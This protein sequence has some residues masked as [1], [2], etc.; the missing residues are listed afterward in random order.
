MSWAGFP[1]HLDQTFVIFG[2]TAIAFFAYI[3][4]LYFSPMREKETT[5]SV[6]DV[7]AVYIVLAMVSLPFLLLV[8]RFVPITK[9][10]IG[11]L[12]S[13]VTVCG[14]SSG[15][16]FVLMPRL[17]FFFFTAILLGFPFVYLL[18][19]DI[20]GIQPLYV[21]ALSP[22]VSLYYSGGAPGAENVGFSW[23]NILVIFGLISLVC[24]VY[25]LLE[26]KPEE[27]T[28]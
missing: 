19:Y 12:L 23:L 9:V 18:L 7:L 13:L 20:W 6:G 17:H 4:P 21:A 26:A 16:F 24:I 1:V 28:P 3:P 15:L 5:T 14:I 2:I 8:R 27:E 10:Q 11:M 25:I 22:F